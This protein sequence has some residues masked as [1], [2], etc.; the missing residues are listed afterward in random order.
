M[1]DLL[2]SVKRR[3][4]STVRDEGKVRRLVITLYPG[5]VIGLRPEKT[6]REELLSVE[7]AWATAVKIRVAQERTQKKAR[8]K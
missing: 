4:N 3:T 7:A 1:T 8:R 6:R 5:G 2:K